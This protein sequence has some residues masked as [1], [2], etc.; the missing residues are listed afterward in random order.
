VKIS[1]KD[2]GTSSAFGTVALV[3]ATEGP[4]AVIPIVIRQGKMEDFEVFWANGNFY[5]LTEKR[6]LQ[7]AGSTS[8]F[9]GKTTDNPTIHDMVK[10]IQPPSEASGY[11]F[12]SSVLSASYEAPSSY[13]YMKDE[14]RNKPEIV[15][16][17]AKNNT[18]TL[19][20]QMLKSA[21]RPAD[22]DEVIKQILRK[23]FAIFRKSSNGMWDVTL[24]SDACYAPTC[25]QVPDE[26][27]IELFRDDEKVIKDVID[28]NDFV[29][30]ANNRK[31]AI[32]MIVTEKTDI[33][34]SPISEPGVY[35]CL[36]KADNTI[37]VGFVF[38]EVFDYSLEKTG[39]M[40]FTNGLLYAIQSNIAGIAKNDDAAQLKKGSPYK[41]TWGTFVIKT[42]DDK[43]KVLKPFKVSGL[44]G[45]SRDLRVHAT[46]IDG[47]GVNFILSDTI[48]FAPEANLGAT[49]L[50]DSGERTYLVP[51]DSIYL[52]LGNSTKLI[53]SQTEFDRTVRMSRLAG[54]I[55]E[56]GYRDMPEN[57][58]TMRY[59][60]K[61]YEIKGQAP[62]QISDTS[63]HGHFSAKNVLM[64]LGLSQADA[65]SILS[66]V[67]DLAGEP[68]TISNLRPIQTPVH[69]N[70]YVTKTASLES[71]LSDVCDVI[72]VDLV[73][74]A[75]F[76]T[77]EDSVDML[78]GLNFITPDSLSLFIENIDNF[79][80]TEQYLARLMLLAQMGLKNAPEGAIK[81]ALEGV[82]K[83]IDYLEELSNMQDYTVL[84]GDSVS[85]SHP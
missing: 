34:F 20:E 80:E 58:I 64:T 77:D 42:E 8:L 71:Q 35:S 51:K 84:S 48:Y 2:E 61:Q 6:F 53:S 45:S 68:V 1:E 62:S 72:R 73:K 47:A 63:M 76:L 30:E 56:G 43:I 69:G 46:D 31:T 83:A 25:K 28:G 85:A 16:N 9:I 66:S 55:Q 54:I 21:P 5:P 65:N 50:G 17:Y 79:K 4:K 27:I 22:D 40:L 75:S 37:Q 49:V 15:A 29:V 11:K 13:Q 14:L 60:N 32:P 78:L 24:N 23:D 52:S 39:Y 59:F 81:K 26:K 18:M 41:G 10:D 57:T 82:S 19:V 36:T 38:P 74:E 12:A 70:T 67:F 3:H 7:K 44:S 33:K